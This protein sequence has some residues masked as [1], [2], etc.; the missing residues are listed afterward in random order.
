[1]MDIDQRR[2][3]SLP[4]RG[5]VRPL[6]EPITKR[7]RTRRLLGS[8]GRASFTTSKGKKYVKLDT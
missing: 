3:V 5:D 4:A 2:K 7:N 1:M 6:R 8:E